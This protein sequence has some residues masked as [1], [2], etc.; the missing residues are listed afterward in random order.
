[1]GSAPCPEKNSILH[2][3]VAILVPPGRYFYSSAAR[4]T[5]K[6]ICFGFEKWL[7]RAYREQNT[8]TGLTTLLLHQHNQPSY[9]FSFH[10]TL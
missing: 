2:L 1:M 5:R 3:K 8:L 10:C 6:N 9:S 7:C 4:F